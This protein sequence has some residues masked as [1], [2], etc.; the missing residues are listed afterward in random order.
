MDL[1]GRMQ[2]PTVT[3][4][5]T[6]TSKAGRSS[7][8]GITNNLLRREPGAPPSLR[9]WV[10]QAD[11]AQ[12]YPRLRLQVGAGRRQADLASARGVGQATA[13]LPSP[14]PP[15][16]RYPRRAA[17]GRCEGARWATAAGRR[18]I[19][20]GVRPTGG[21][22]P[23][24]LRGGAR[25]LAAAAGRVRVLLPHRRLPGLR[26]RR[27]RRGRA[28]GRDGGRRGLARGGSRPGAQPLRDREHGAGARRAD[29]AAQLV[30]RPRAAGAQPHAQGGDGG[31][32]G[33]RR[34]PRGGGAR[35]QAAGGAGAGGPCRW[36]SSPTRSC[37]PRTS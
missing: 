23:R 9:R 33:P 27:R 26:P 12:G 37:R 18:R 28:R 5:D 31:A 24:A 34:R 35:G 30:R 4:T 8:R 11:R 17:D 10:D 7:T 19:L 32:G 25:E 21:A 13:L 16:P 3:P 2:W 15:A 29:G 14:H 6:T 36:R 1:H 22:P 20:T